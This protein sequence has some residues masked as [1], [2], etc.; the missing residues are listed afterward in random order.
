MAST[1]LD[2]T[3]KNRKCSYCKKKVPAESTVRSGLRAFCSIEHLVEFSKSEAGQKIIKKAILKDTREQKENIRSK[4]DWMKLAQA[5]VN[6][7]V[8]FR[9]RDQGCISCGARPEQKRGGT[10][11]A[12]HYRSRGA[13]GHLRFN[14]NN[15]HA[16][17][18]KCN[19]HLSGNVVE[20]RINL[21][22]RIGEDK[23]QQLEE[24]FTI[25]NF[26]VD[27]LKR[28]TRIFRKRLRIE[29]KIAEKS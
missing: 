14:T 12:G 13:A 2:V 8:K 19:R 4:S 26:D 27:Y 22:R 23:V 7:W 1:A 10:V 29:K 11:D 17:C 20:Y 15:I 16:Q 21:I 28:I 25:R 24:D 9:D 5:A 18:V 3:P 6:Q